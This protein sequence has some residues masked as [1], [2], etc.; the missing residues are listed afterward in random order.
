MRTLYKT[1]QKDAILQIL[2]SN[3]KTSFNAEKILELLQKQDKKVSK[4][5]LYRFL[6]SC[7]ENL[8]TR[9]TFNAES[10]SYEYQYVQENNAHCSSHFHLKCVNC[11]ALIHLECEDA[12]EFIN[13][14]NKEHGF[15]IDQNLSTIF[16]LCKKCVKQK[17]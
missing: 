16:G 17:F 7:T 2:K 10:K 1:Q 8:I 4:A 11:G 9:K 3:S 6:D 13:H 14:I 12:N 5:T 15:L